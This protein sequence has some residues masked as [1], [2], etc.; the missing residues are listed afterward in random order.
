MSLSAFLKHKWNDGFAAAW[1]VGEV[2]LVG[3]VLSQSPDGHLVESGHHEH[4]GCKITTT[5]TTIQSI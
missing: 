2:L 5:T 3:A 1:I 4:S